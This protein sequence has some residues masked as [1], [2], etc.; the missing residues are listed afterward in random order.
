[1]S[2]TTDP[3]AGPGGYYYGWNVVA[4][5][6]ALQAVSI[7]ISI[8]SFALFVVPW[9]D[10]FGVDR[11]QVMFA[12]FLAQVAMGAMSPLCGRLLDRF[13]I[14]VL[15]V[16][17]CLCQAAGLLVM[18]L[19]TAFWQIVAAYATLMPLGMVFAGTLAS[20]TLVTRWFT[21]R[22]GVAIGV[23]AMGTS[24][25]GFAFPLLIA[26]LISSVGWQE[27][28]AVLAALSV[29]LTVPGALWVLRRSPP[30]H[31]IGG[32]R[33]P[34]ARQWTAREVLATRTFWIPVVALVPVNASFGGVQFSLGAYVFD[35][36][37]EQGVAATLIAITSVSNI[38]GKFLFG[39]LGD[40][41][42]HRLLFW[43]MA[44]CLAAALVVYIVAPGF[45][46]LAV[47][48]SLQGLATGG[49]LPLMGLIYAG[50]F[51]VS[52]FGRVMGL[53]NLFLTAGSVGSVYSGWIFDL[54]GSYL[55][56]FATFLILLLPGA[57]WMRWLPRYGTATA[58]AERGD[59]AA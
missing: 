4:L 2:D 22:R 39:S 57:I 34:A 33:A 10:A 51:G 21:T 24:V 1:M 47:A 48:A 23:S 12:I 11:A 5:T 54:T 6:L 17:G 27:T 36:G 26:P 31:G 30:G 15:V 7:G 53:V 13:S 37:L 18:S 56:A 52:S 41:V 38:V 44:A 59:Q 43:A 20:Q 3:P 19:A 28:L 40:R 46:A 50:R 8:Y 32:G 45:S 42:E 55:P 29:L 14:R 58:A 35:L 9:L 25:G 49:V 16:V